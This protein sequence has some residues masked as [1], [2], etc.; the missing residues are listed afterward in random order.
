M[1]ASTLR[2]VPWTCQW[3]RS[4]VAVEQVSAR[5]SQ[6]DDVFW[7]CHHP[8]TSPHFRMVDTS[9]CRTCPVWKAA[10]RLSQS[11]PTM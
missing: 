4:G 2:R 8:V 6:V 5:E 7:V 3:G 11:P 10:D 9:E 1:N